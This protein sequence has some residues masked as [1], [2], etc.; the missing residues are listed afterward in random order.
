MPT[1][2]ALL[3][4]ALCLLFASLGSLGCGSSEEAKKTY[5]GTCEFSED[6]A[7]PLSCNAGVC[8]TPCSDGTDCQGLGPMSRCF[9]G[10]CFDA[11]TPTTSCPAGLQCEM[12]GTTA[13]SCRA[14]RF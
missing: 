3:A 7:E 4:I 14:P 13:G 2:R 8:T 9:S 12:V 11:C 1:P 5:S 6:C 10:T